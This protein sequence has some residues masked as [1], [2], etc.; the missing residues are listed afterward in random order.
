MRKWFT[1]FSLMACMMTCMQVTGM[2]QQNETMPDEDTAKTAVVKELLE[3]TG[4]RQ[5]T[6]MMMQAT[7]I[8]LKQTFPGLPDEFLDELEKELNYDS[9]VIKIVPIY[10]RHWS[11]SDIKGLIAFYKTPLGQ[12]MIRETPKIMQ[13]YMEMNMEQTKILTQRAL[14]RM[15]QKAQEETEEQPPVMF[16]E[17]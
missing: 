12:K 5:N 7:V 14:E 9:L 10:T 8:K 4:S 13:E 6:E 16:Q 11:I 2:A 1:A 3:L 15:E 17:Q